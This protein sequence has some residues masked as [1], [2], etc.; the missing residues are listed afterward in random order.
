MKRILI[1]DDQPEIRELVRMT[2]EM[3]G[4]EIHEA[5]RG[6]TALTMARQLTPDLL[7]LDV[8]MPGTLDGLAVC[9]AIKADARHKATK[10]VILSARGQQDD[11]QAG[12]SAGA[13]AYLTKP[14]SPRNLLAMVD[15]ML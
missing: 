13:D 3:E 2:L 12:L 11:R 10:V 15:R 6:D 8:M 7:L 4:H 5:D 14:F 9:R 1:V